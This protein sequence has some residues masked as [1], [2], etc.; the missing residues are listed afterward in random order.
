MSV[1]EWADAGHWLQ[2]SQATLSRES[3]AVTLARIAAGELE[4]WVLPWLPLLRGAA[5]AATIA[6]WQR[7]A[8]QEP[9][10]R[11]RSDFGALALVFAELAG[12]ASAWRKALKGWN[13]RESPQVLE[14]Q[15]EA[16]EQALFE[17]GKED[18]QRAVLRRFGTPLPADL[19]D[20]LAALHSMAE[21]DRWFDASVTAPSL[22]VFRAAVQNGKRKRK[23][24]AP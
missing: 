16:R 7:L 21:L 23:R 19:A 4:R 10:G 9:D 6:E 5:E 12:T 20:Q 11:S 22:D 3:A 15:R 8:A 1:P 24:S 17:R 18:V 13:M 2:I 14:W